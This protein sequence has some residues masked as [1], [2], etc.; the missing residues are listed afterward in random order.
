MPSTMGTIRPKVKI[1][2]FYFYQN[3]SGH[4]LFYREGPRCPMCRSKYSSV[5]RLFLSNLPENG[6]TDSLQL[7]IL[8]GKIRERRATTDTRQN[9]KAHPQII[10]A[11][12][13]SDRRATTDDRQQTNK[14][15]IES[16]KRTIQEQAEAVPTQASIQ[17]TSVKRHQV[18]NSSALCDNQ[19]STN[20]AVI[21]ETSGSI[22]RTKKTVKRIN[23][24]QS[25]API[26]QTARTRASFQ[27]LKC[28]KC[29]KNINGPNERL[30]KLRLI[31]CYACYLKR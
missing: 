13:I 4:I 8:S 2:Y 30:P 31:I 22:E 16:V 10:R 28:F 3:M 19:Q 24:R 17:S 7:P 21:G 9:N 5:G 15:E 20:L 6:T 18:Q 11:K 14:R 27:R 1:T 26:R 29:G 23:Q 25:T 12:T